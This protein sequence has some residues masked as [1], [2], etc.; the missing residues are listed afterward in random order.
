MRIKNFI[1]CFLI[2]LLTQISKPMSVKSNNRLYYS[3]NNEYRKILRCDDGITVYPDIAETDVRYDNEIENNSLLDG[4]YSVDNPYDFSNAENI[5]DDVIS[6]FKRYDSSACFV[7]PDKFE[8]LSE[9]SCVVN[10]NQLMKLKEDNVD[11]KSQVSELQHQYV[12]YYFSDSKKEESSEGSYTP[13]SNV[14]LINVFV[15]G[16]G[17]NASHWSNNGERLENRHAHI[18]TDSL[19]YKVMQK[20]N[21]SL[22]LAWPQLIDDKIVDYQCCQISEFDTTLDLPLSTLTKRRIVDNSVLLYEDETTE[23]S[24]TER[25][26]NNFKIY[27]ER[28]MRFYPDARFNLFG[29]SRGGDLNL[30]FASDYP[31]KVIDMFSLGTPYYSPVLA[32]VDEFVNSLPNNGLSQVIK[33]SLNDKGLSHI[34][35]YSSLAD[36]ESMYQMRKNWNDKNKSSNLYTIGYGFGL[37]MSWFI[38]FLWW[39]IRIDISIFVPWDVLVGMVNA[40]GQPSNSFNIRFLNF[41]LE[42]TGASDYREEINC[43]ER[44]SI[45]IDT[46][47]ILDVLIKNKTY[48][49]SSPDAPAIPHNLETMYYKTSEFILSKL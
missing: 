37:E 32:N 16:I 34:D 31:D 23:N 8:P 5:A 18:R 4:F 49:C 43:K 21:S 14:K 15:P 9:S 13:G 47:Y 19:P 20:Y 17:G 28:L 46:S 40:M 27:M 22:Y 1:I 30:M 36:E 3:S 42:L 45:I 11:F 35:A 6:Y 41:I 29:H 10:L 24:T 7:I 12:D 44:K 2:I 38:K 25:A 39:T 48:L 33:K 26:Y